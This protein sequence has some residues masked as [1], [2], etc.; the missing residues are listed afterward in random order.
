MDGVFIVAPDATIMHYFAYGSNMSISRLGQRVRVAHRVG[1]CRLESH[2]LRFHKAGKDGSA[3][4]DAFETENPAH[5]V[6]G[7]L[8]TI[9]AA[10][11]P[12]L[13]QV[14][15]LGYG[16]E[17]KWVTVIDGSGQRF[18]AFTYCATS[19]DQSLKPFSWYLNHV[20]V[21][22]RECGVPAGYLARIEQ[23]EYIEDPDILRDQRERAIHQSRSQMTLNSCS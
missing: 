4:C 18:E 14:E 9:D 8:F 13:D 21:G 22:A 5:F 10:T 3:K 20:L 6:L 7:S 1:L 12:Q 11:K 23:I 17:E 16:Y 15:G 19:I 2:E